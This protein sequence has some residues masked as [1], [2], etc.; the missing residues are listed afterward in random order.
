MANI[1]TIKKQ[2][3]RALQAP[4]YNAMLQASIL[5]P[6]TTEPA[7]DFGRNFDRD[8]IPGLTRYARWSMIWGSV[9]VMEIGPTPRIEANGSIEISGFTL[10][11][12]E[13][14]AN[15]ALLAVALA[16]YVYNAEF[17]FEGIRVTVWETT[18]RQGAK[19]GTW[20]FCPMIVKWTV[21]RT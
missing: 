13:E 19:D 6:G 17:E 15:D 12:D 20:R 18:P 14:D 3:R 11:K 2:I 7:I 9:T 10:W 8:S 5:L 16:P 4:L 1:A 21:L